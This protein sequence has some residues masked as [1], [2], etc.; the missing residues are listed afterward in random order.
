MELT[1]RAAAPDDLEGV[2]AALADGRR[3]IAALG[4]DQW[5]GGYPD[6]G[7]V[8]EDIRLGAC[9]VAVDDTGVLVA[10]LALRF[11]IDSDYAASAV[12]WL[13]GDG[14]AE[15]RY[16]AIHR[17]ATAAGAARRGVMSA[18]VGYAAAEAVAAG[19]GSLR[20]DTHPG[21][22]VMRSFLA[23]QGFEER[24]TLR[25]ARSND[26]D[27]TRVAFERALEGARP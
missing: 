18:L 3:A 23:R 7:T 12:P 9:R 25:L 21:N 14:G 13:T 10:T 27:P 11:D 1:F 4:I 22:T 19:C 16:A 20:A 2:M 24:G 26:G 17:V 6:R 5:Q 15:F 8:E